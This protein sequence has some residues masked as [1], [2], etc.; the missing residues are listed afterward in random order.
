MYEQNIHEPP[1]LLLIVEQIKTIISYLNKINL[2]F[3]YTDT[4]IKFT[5]KLLSENTEN[6]IK[7]CIHYKKTTIELDN[8]LSKKKKTKKS[9]LLKLQ[10]R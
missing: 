8:F 7:S 2:F 6:K 4:D 5:I 10:T 3:V 9:G 1:I